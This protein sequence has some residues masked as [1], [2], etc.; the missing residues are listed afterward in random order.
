MDAKLSELSF[1]RTADDGQVCYV[2]FNKYDVD[3][4][5]EDARVTI[6]YEDFEWFVA[7]IEKGRSLFGHPKDAV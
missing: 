2:A 5:Y 3:I 6:P 1:E 7:A 4:R